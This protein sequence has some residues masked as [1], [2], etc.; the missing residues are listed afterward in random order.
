MVL[1]EG[2]WVLHPGQDLQATS[3][4]SVGEGGGRQA[5]PSKASGPMG[6]PSARCDCRLMRLVDRSDGASIPQPELGRC[7]PRRLR[8]AQS[9]RRWN[10]GGCRRRKRENYIDRV[11]ARRRAIHN[12]PNPASI[13]IP[14]VGS[15]TGVATAAKETVPLYSDQTGESGTSDTAVPVIFNT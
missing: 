15:G 4:G 13:N 1:K 11:D 9:G 12:A 10:V 3:K 7:A 8:Q 2:R 14:T 5:R 6:L